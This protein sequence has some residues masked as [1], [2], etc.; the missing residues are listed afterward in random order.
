M[1][2]AYL[3]CLGG[4]A[5]LSAQNLDRKNPAVSTPRHAHDAWSLA[6][7]DPNDMHHRERTLFSKR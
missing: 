5:T 6:Y 2:E 4:A 3:K 7:F 1:R